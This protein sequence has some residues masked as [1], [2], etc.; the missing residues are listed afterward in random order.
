MRTEGAEEAESSLDDE[1]AHKKGGKPKEQHDVGWEVHRGEEHDG[2]EEQVEQNAEDCLHHL[3]REFQEGKEHIHR[4]VHGLLEGAGGLGRRLLAHS[5]GEP[6]GLASSILSTSDGSWRIL[7][8]G[9]GVLL[10]L[11][12]DLLEVEEVAAGILV[13]GDGRSRGNGVC[14]G[15]TCR[16][17][18]GCLM[19]TMPK[20][21]RWTREYVVNFYGFVLV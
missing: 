16:R 11:L 17:Q 15:G 19:P 2:A 6:P 4:L 12:L 7:A 14:S 10:C 9:F 13:R 8:E 1:R 18:C 20:K 21:G 3:V 5:G